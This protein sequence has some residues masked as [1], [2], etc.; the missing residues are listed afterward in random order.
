MTDTLHFLVRAEAV[1]HG[2]AA[3]CSGGQSAPDNFYRLAKRG[4]AGRARILLRLAPVNNGAVQ[5]GV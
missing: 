1:V 3:I 2:R 4:P 5:H